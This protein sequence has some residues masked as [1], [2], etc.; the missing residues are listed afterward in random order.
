M[1]TAWVF[2]LFSAWLG[3]YLGRDNLK[4]MTPDSAPAYWKD[5]V[6]SGANQE[7]KALE[8]DM[9]AL[10]I[11]LRGRQVS[12]AVPKSMHDLL[13]RPGILNAHKDPDWLGWVGDF[14][15]GNEVERIISMAG[16][17]G[18]V[19]GGALFI[20]YD[21]QSVVSL[22][23]GFCSTEVGLT[24]WGML[25]RQS[26]GPHERWVACM[27]EANLL[28][29]AV[30]LE[31]GQQTRVEPLP[32]DTRW[33]MHALEQQVRQKEGLDPADNTNLETLLNFPLVKKGWSF[34]DVAFHPQD[35]LGAIQRLVKKWPA[36]AVVQWQA[37]SAD[38]DRIIDSLTALSSL[39]RSAELENALPAPSVVRKSGPRF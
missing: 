14:T 20:D 26:T 4:N 8:G 36:E 13:M 3:E 18:P 39:L 1:G 9:M 37:W 7:M 34:H 11:T 2:M 6:P 38:P 23:D 25:S 16:G 12:Y 5:H 32:A 24:R 30:W 19:D 15:E 33:R 17:F 31:T 28:P 21:A 22:H 27:L 29:V 10:H 35:A